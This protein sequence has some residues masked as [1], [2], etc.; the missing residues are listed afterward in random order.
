MIFGSCSNVITLG[1]PW[2]LH[3]PL[4][5]G[6]AVSNKVAVRQL[7]PCVP[8]WQTVLPSPRWNHI[9]V[10]LANLSSSPC[11]YNV[12]ATADRQ[13]LQDATLFMVRS[14]VTWHL[15]KCSQSGLYP[16]SCMVNGTSLTPFY[17]EFIILLYGRQWDY[18]I[19]LW[20]PIASI[21]LW[22]IHQLYLH[23]NNP[24]TNLTSLSTLPL[25]SSPRSLCTL[26]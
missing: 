17:G 26:G 21:C 7:A 13:R 2:C 6:Y 15:P 25:R 12:M 8:I 5:I 14:S 23:L 9:L 22:H 24:S 20:E 18:H 11:T 19:L 1:N 16:P 10:T 3:H 4:R